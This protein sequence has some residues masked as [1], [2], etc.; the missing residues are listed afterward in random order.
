MLTKIL[1]TIAVIGGVLIFFSWK[2]QSSGP[3]LPSARQARSSSPSGS[4][5]RQLAVGVVITMVLGSALF[6]YWEWQTDSEVV[7]VRVIDTRSGNVGEYRAY[8]GEIGERSFKTLD[9]RH[10]SLAETERM[11]TAAVVDRKK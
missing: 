3:L 1:F 11:E 10:V 2:R 7:I 8:Q 6:F 4:L 9:G 5:V